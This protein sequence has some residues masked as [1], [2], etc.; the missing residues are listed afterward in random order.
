VIYDGRLPHYHQGIVE[1][2]DHPDIDNRHAWRHL[3][4]TFYN[5]NLARRFAANPVLN[6]S[7]F[8]M[9]AR[10]T[11]AVRTPIKRGLE[12]VTEIKLE[13]ALYVEYL[14][15]PFVK[16]LRSLPE[17]WNSMD[18]M[19]RSRLDRD[20]VGFCSALSDHM[21]LVSARFA[22]HL[23]DQGRGDLVRARLVRLN[24]RNIEGAAFGST[25]A[26]ISVGL[27]AGLQDYAVELVAYSLAVGQAV[28]FT[29]TGL[30]SC[31]P[32]RFKTREFKKFETDLASFGRT[33]DGPR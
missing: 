8:K 31:V 9:P 20:V 25:A 11:R 2:A 18:R 23:H 27:W 1:G 12:N 22:K 10:L 6:T 5:F 3:I 17:F 14:T 28:G 26:M 21:K 29:V 30:L 24:M 7:W 15:F 32:V 13:T 33:L 16:R 4:N 19:D